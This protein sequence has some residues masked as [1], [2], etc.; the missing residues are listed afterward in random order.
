M[1]NKLYLVTGGAGFLGSNICRLLS[2]SGNRVRT[3]VL[4]GDPA[5]KYVPEGTEIVHGDLLDS[6][7]LEPFFRTGEDEE[8]YVIHCAGIVWAKP[9]VNPKVHAVNVDG[10]ANIIEKCAGAFSCFQT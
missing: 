9:E 3:L 4:E 2:E 10:T 1:K 8:V 5:E 6:G 7:S